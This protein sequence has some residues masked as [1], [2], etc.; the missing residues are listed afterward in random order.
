MQEKLKELTTQFRNG[1]IQDEKEYNER[2]ASMQKFYTSEMEKNARLYGVAIDT[3]NRV[4]AD[5]WSTDF[6]DLTTD[7]SQWTTSVTTYLNE[8]AT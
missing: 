7:T 2:I 1:E 8:S 6:A 5:S 3:D 4:I